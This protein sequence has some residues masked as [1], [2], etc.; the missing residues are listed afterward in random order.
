MES[1]EGFEVIDYPSSTYK[2]EQSD[3]FRLMKD[4]L[5]SE[6]NMIACKSVTPE[7]EMKLEEPIQKPHS[8]QRQPEPKKPKSKKKKARSQ[9]SNY[10]CF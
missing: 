4:K 7:T 2:P 5:E 3:K 8:P 6:L 1:F 10:C 9:C